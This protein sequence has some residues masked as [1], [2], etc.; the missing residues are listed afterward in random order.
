[1]GPTVPSAQQTLVAQ[2]QWGLRRT[3]VSQNP[4]SQVVILLTIEVGASV[5]RV[6]EWDV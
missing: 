1:M 2:L 3:I 5:E 4:C 6:A